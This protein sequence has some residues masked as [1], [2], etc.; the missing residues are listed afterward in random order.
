MS[1]PAQQIIASPYLAGNPTAPTPP[2]GDNSEAVATTAYVESA[3]ATGIAETPIVNTF[4]SRTGNV[5]LEAVDVENAL[6]YVPTSPALVST[7]VTSLQNQI[8]S[9]G[10]QVSSVQTQVN[11][12]TTI[13]ANGIAS[14]TYQTSGQYSYQGINLVDQLMIIVFANGES[15][16]FSPGTLQQ[17]QWYSPQHYTSMSF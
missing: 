10:S 17:G 6:G 16:I 7:D 1:L 2:A 13:A 9:I 14:I 5:Q 15:R 11:N 8:N 3:I 12:N 4:N